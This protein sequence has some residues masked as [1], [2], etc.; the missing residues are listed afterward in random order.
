MS[1]KMPLLSWSFTPGANL[2]AILAS[3][4]VAGAAAAQD[5]FPQAPTRA[6]VFRWL[7][8]NSDLSA[9]AV[10]AMTD[11]VVVAIAD[12]Q[13]GRGMD[14]SIRLTLRE[15]VINADAAATWG[16]RSMQLNLDLDCSRHRV[17]LGARRIYVRPNLQGSVR[18]TRSDDAWTEAPSGTVVDDVVRAVCEPQLAQAQAR[19][20]PA[21]EAA[22]AGPPPVAAT[23]PANAAAAAPASP[24]LTAAAE[25]APELG[26]PASGAALVTVQ[27]AQP[28]KLAEADPPPVAADRS[29]VVHNPFANPAAS[30]Q[31]LAATPAPRAVTAIPSAPRPPDFAVQIATVTSADLARDDWQSLKA[32]FPDLISPRTFAAEPVSADGRTLYRAL[33]LG[34][35]SQDEAS[36]LCK[37]LRSQSVDCTLRQLK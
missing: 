25:P 19:P 18:L 34:F 30:R 36:A 4:C 15:E 16:G 11:E 14:G 3:A 13:D 21:A 29:V 33:L 9:G 27:P 22:A 7:A 35:A 6:D 20:A 12:R 10:V 17:V 24:V 2:A 5:T 31:S 1:R 37:A 32:K 26:P 8:A 23:S 28:I